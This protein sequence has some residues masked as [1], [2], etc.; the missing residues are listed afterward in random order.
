MIAAIV[1]A[2]IAAAPAP[3]GIQYLGPK[4]PAKV[5]RVITIAPSITELVIALGAKDRLVGVS[6]FDALP[7]VDKLPRVGGW[8]DPS[9]EA[10]LALKPDLVIVQPGPANRAPVE[11]MAELGAPVLSIAMQ[12]VNQVVAAM[13]EVAKVLG[14]PETGEKLARQLEQTREEIRAKAKTAPKQKVLVVYGFQPFVVAGPGSFVD[15]LVRDAGG[16]NAAAS[17]K[18]AYAVYSAESAIRAKPDVVI[19]AVM[20]HEAGGDQLKALPGL[21]EARW[22][23]VPSEDLLHPGPNIARGLRALFEMI[24]PAKR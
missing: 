6:R 5:Q 10:V 2:L 4:P 22:V 16:I 7:E 17:A 21:K 3:A 1:G 19:D 24:H 18:T 12:D 13:R 20:G 11:K 23:T 8:I 9:V 14:V 15:E